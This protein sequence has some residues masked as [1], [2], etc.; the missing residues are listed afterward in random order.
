VRFQLHKLYRVDYE[1]KCV[2]LIKEAIANCFKIL[3][4]FHGGTEEDRHKLLMVSSQA[5]NR[6]QDLLNV[7]SS[8]P[9]D[10]HVRGLLR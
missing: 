1:N 7:K 10:R 9:L 8:S 6:T 3:S 4:H 2:W 5:D